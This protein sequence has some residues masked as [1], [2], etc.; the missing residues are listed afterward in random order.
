MLRRI[1]GEDV[2]LKT[3]LHSHLDHVKA[4]RGQCEQVLLNLVVNARDAMPNGGAL[5]IATNNLELKPESGGEAVGGRPGRC[6]MLS[7]TDS[8]RGMPET[9]KR[10]IFEP[11]FTTKE[12]GRGTGLGLAVVHGIVKQ[13]GGHIEVE[14]KVGAGASFKIYLPSVAQPAPLAT[15]LPAD[16]PA[17]SGTET[18]L[19][20]EDEDGVRALARNVLQRCGYS[21]LEASNRDEALR[22]SG[23]Y[24]KPIE[25]LV[26]DVVMPGISGRVLAMQLRNRRPAIKVLYISGY[27]DEALIRHGILQ[28]KVNFL[29]KPF[30]PAALA[31]KVREALA[32]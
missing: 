1:I 6:V 26:V 27:T 9:V 28:E 21:V 3:V 12:P 18:I 11:F 31:H 24:R 10:R 20:V 16:G 30:L 14:S 22:V 7:V 23:D 15:S 13:S 25:L 5:T 32:K 8:G 2:H 17:P 29:Q 4:D 19:L